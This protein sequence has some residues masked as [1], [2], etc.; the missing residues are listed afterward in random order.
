LNF[1]VGK[2]LAATCLSN[3]AGDPGADFCALSSTVA[4]D[5]EVFQ[6]LSRSAARG[7]GRREVARLRTSLANL[8]D[9]AY[10][11]PLNVYS[12][13][14]LA[15]PESTSS[16]ML[17]KSFVGKE[18]IFGV[19]VESSLIRGDRRPAGV[20]STECRNWL[21]DNLTGEQSGSGRQCGIPSSQ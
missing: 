21:L 17:K 5:V 4:V 2:I 6:P 12:Y 1:G 14:L 15:R 19:E 18:I 20:W 8:Y 13:Q 10:P 16:Q 3:S 9:A 11:Q 7:N